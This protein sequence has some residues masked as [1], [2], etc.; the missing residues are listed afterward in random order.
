MQCTVCPPVSLGA[1]WESTRPS[2][3]QCGNHRRHTGSWHLWKNCPESC[4]SLHIG[5]DLHWGW[6][7]FFMGN[8]NFIMLQ[9]T[10]NVNIKQ[11]TNWAS[12]LT[13][14]WFTSPCRPQGTYDS[15]LC[16]A[17]LYGKITW[18]FVIL[19]RSKSLI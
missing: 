5:K 17:K 12:L 13:S 1:G 19:Q 2:M 16:L 10:V 6:V 9:K 3:R 11:R 8:K 4:L 7:L 14:K 15:S 18:S